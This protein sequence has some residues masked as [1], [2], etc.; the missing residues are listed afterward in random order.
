MSKRKHSDPLIT[1]EQTLQRRAWIER[2]L[3]GVRRA[4]ERVEDSIEPAESPPRP[5]LY[6]VGSSSPR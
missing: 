6:V 2:A 1:N 3:D 4:T 5:K